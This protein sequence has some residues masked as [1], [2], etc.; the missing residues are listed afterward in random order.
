M[1]TLAVLLLVF[2]VS[3][4]LCLGAAVF[5]GVMVAFIAAALV[6]GTSTDSKP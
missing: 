3:A 5:I 1:L 6:T 2:A 4:I